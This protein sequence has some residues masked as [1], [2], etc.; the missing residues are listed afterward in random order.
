MHPRMSRRLV[1]L[2]SSSVYL[3]LKSFDGQ[4]KAKMEMRTKATG[5]CAKSRRAAD[6]G[7]F[8]FKKSLKI[9]NCAH[10]RTQNARKRPKTERNGNCS[11]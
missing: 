4:Q 7:G 5:L 10:A 2:V 9:L 3:T 1:P 11:C 6:G 8:R